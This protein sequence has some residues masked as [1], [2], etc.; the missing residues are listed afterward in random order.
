MSRLS[1]YNFNFIFTNENEKEKEQ[2]NTVCQ[3]FFV[4]SKNL[5]FCLS[6]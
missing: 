6:R 4:D 1:V 2:H 5:D 3:M